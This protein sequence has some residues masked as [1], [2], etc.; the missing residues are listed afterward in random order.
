MAWVDLPLDRTQKLLE[1]WK[2]RLSVAA[3]NEPRTTV[4][5]GETVALR[6]FLE[7]LQR[8]KI[9]CQLLSFG[10]GFHSPLMTQF[11]GELSK[12]LEGIRP[13]HSDIPI[14]ST[15]TGDY[16]FGH[17]LD[18]NYWAK[19]IRETVL[20]VTAINRLLDSGIEIFLEISPH[21]LLT[22]SVTQCLTHRNHQGTV[23]HSL[24]RERRARTELSKSLKALRSLGVPDRGEPVA[25]IAHKRS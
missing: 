16:V 4:V 25:S 17:T 19:N 7:S 23:L 21:A 3:N 13:R 12:A 5:S 1:R 15:V 6:H 20:F 11:Q 14:V 22:G 2:D 10:H 9:L 8:K 24:H 18:N